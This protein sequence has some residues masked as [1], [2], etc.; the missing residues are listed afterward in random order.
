MII[1]SCNKYN[2]NSGTLD[3][4]GMHDK[5]GNINARNRD[6]KSHQYFVSR[7]MVRDCMIILIL[8]EVR[9]NVLCTGGVRVYYSSYSI[10][11]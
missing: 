10:E 7:Q 5:Q 4:S 8:H 2:G 11:I 6:E 1:L 3:K 9:N